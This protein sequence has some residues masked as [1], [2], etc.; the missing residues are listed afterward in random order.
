MKKLYNIPP[1]Y[2]AQRKASEIQKIHET[3]ISNGITC[4]SIEDYVNYL[5][6]HGGFTLTDGT[7]EQGKATSEFKDR[8]TNIGIVPKDYGSGRGYGRNDHMYQKN[9]AIS[10]MRYGNSTIGEAGCGP[11]AAA[12][13]LNNVGKGKAGVVNAAKYAERNGFVSSD[14]GTDINYFNSYL[15]AN[16][17][18]N[19][20]TDS[21]SDVVSAL[22]SGNQAIILGQGTSNSVSDPYSTRPHFITAKGIDS[23]GDVLVEDPDLSTS[24]RKVSAKRLF[25]GMK[26]SVLAGIGSGRTAMQKLL[27]YGTL[28]EADKKLLS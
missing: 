6:S 19:S 17:I 21:P 2:I 11:V 7:V 1:N 13:L 15:S 4:N 26:A 20:Q 9:S 22:R 24:T 14:G 8:I 12:N 28:T 16:G 5:N 23:N 10:N 27:G 25:Q 18:P 3:I